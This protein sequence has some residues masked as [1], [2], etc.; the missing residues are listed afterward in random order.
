MENRINVTRSLLPPFEEYIEE[1]R[2][3]WENHWLTNMGEKHQ[4]L[5]QK[6]SSY[7][8]V[9]NI[10]LMSN[11]HMAL[12]LSL[13]AL[14]L[15]PG[16]QVITTPFT[17]AS[18]THAIVRNNLEPVF[19]DISPTD[20]TMDV[21]KLEG[22]VTDKTVAILPVHVYGNICNVEEIGRL[23]GKHGL[24]VIYDAAHAFGETYRGVGVGNFGDA[25]MFSFHATKVFNTIEG[26]AV[27]YRDEEFG[28]KLYRLKNFGIR[29]EEVVDGVGA[30]AKMNEFQAAMGLCNLCHVDG[31]IEKRRQATEYYRERL[32]GIRGLRLNVEQKGVTSNYAYFPILVEEGE[33]GVSRDR[34]CQTL[35]EQGIYARK[36]FYPLTNSFA[37]YKG[38]FDARTTPV[39]W[40]ISKQV[41][42]LPLY[43]D[44]G[45]QEQC[46]I[47]DT[48]LGLGN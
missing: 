26:G 34:V 41:L 38:R 16:G 11:G 44:L 20:F 31:E 45:K 48:I 32:G 12:E 4:K 2:P 6:L 14:E 47:C 19:C 5:E 3:M 46:T 9:P 33:F 8:Q 39:A 37:C 28:L 21:A 36:Y 13:Q 42:T 24:R 25:S 35:R 18:T 1:I 27:C 29:N 7:L 22:L 17:F 30:N 15:E 10:S 40:K 23:A 43:G